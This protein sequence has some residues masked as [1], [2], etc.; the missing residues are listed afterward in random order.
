MN[1][2]SRISLLSICAASLLI[3]QTS[4][5]REDN[6]PNSDQTWAV[7]S[8]DA[9]MQSGESDNVMSDVSNLMESADIVGG[10]RTAAP[11]VCGGTITQ[12][13]R[14]V[15]L[16]FDGTTLCGDRRRS[17]VIT[18]ELISGDKFRDINAVLKVNFVNY[19]VSKNYLSEMRTLTFNGVH[20]V[21]NLTGG[22]LANMA[23]GQTITH[24]VSGNM[25]LTFTDG[26]VRTW[27]VARLR[28]FTRPNGILTLSIKGDTVVNGITQVE[29][30][31][32]NRFGTSFT[33]ETVTPIVVNQ[34][35]GWYKPLSGQR[36]HKLSTGRTIA[37][38]FG[39][40]NEGTASSSACPDY[41]KVV[42]TAANGRQYTG[43]YP[44]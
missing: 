29:V 13:G 7:H 38:T 10:G 3:L 16:T 5:R 40:N 19:Q 22:L 34:T 4:C 43:V 42:F 23:A 9:S 2:K 17:G 28:S 33:T 27:K 11:S 8:Q 44:Y 32:T 20:Y 37:V 21:K 26:G 24:R 12:N 6:S 30:A 39:T 35:C 36:L 31:G 15:T 25:N 1:S 14:L 41:F 18:L